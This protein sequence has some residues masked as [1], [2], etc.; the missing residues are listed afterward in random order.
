MERLT[1]DIETIPSTK[2]LS[3]VLE[4]SLNSRLIRELAYTKETDENEVKRRLQAVNPFYGEICVIGFQQDNKDPVALY[5]D[6]KEVLENFWELIQGFKGTFVTFNGLKFDVPYIIVRSEYHGLRPTNKNF[7]N[8]RRFFYYPHFDCYSVVTDWE[9]IRGISLKVACDF[10]GI[11][12]SKDGEVVASN[13]AEYVAKGEIEKV[14][15]YC[16][17]DVRATAELHTILSRFIS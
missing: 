5:G 15:E 8:K 4:A 7:L 11:R 2:K 9:S 14:A 16:N 13:V 12:G 17:E 6:E 1:F 3:P 10:F